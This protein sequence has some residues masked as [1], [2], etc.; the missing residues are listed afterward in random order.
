[1]PNFNKNTITL[2]GRKL[3]QEA[4]IG[5]KAISFQKFSIGD[6]EYPD[7]PEILTALSHEL[8][9]VPVAKT[10]A[11]DTEAGVTIARCSF[12][13]TE[14]KGD[15]YLRE[16]GIFAKLVDSD[17]SPVLFAYAYDD[18]ADFIPSVGAAS[19]IE[20]GIVMHIV[21]GSAEVLYVVDPSAAT[22][23]KDIQELE[24]RVEDAMN[25]LNEEVQNKID[26]FT[27]E[28]ITELT[29]MVD[30]VKNDVAAAREEI[31]TAASG[32]VAKTGDTMT[33]NLNLGTN[34]VIGS[35]QG[36][37]TQWNGWT[38]YNSISEIGNLSWTSSR[39]EI[40][41]AMPAKSIL[42]HSFGA[43]NS[44]MPA[45]TGLLEIRKVDSSGSMIFTDPAGYSWVAGVNNNSC[46]DWR[47]SFGVPTGSIQM[48]AGATA[49]AGYLLC[50][51]QSVSRSTYANLFAAIGTTYGNNDSSTFK[52]PDLRGVFPRGYDAGRGL[53]SGRKLGS[54]QDSGSPNIS[55][56]WGA[57]I[58]WCINDFSSQT[59]PFYRGAAGNRV[60]MGGGGATD[61]VK[62]GL[63]ASKSSSVYKNGLS[64]VRPKNLAVNFIIKY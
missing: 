23:L 61:T 63:D 45:A 10:Y 27:E 26:A 56:I 22:S 24:A 4:I 48:F 25:G 43:K 1:M 47:T 36:S 52:L 28:K 13:N 39:S 54:Y 18:K 15:F 58:T 8:F 62:I 16:I 59:A 17:A 12:Q 51:G 42:Y 11:S 2:E 6:G 31:E 34:K 5:N 20:Q 41:S 14:E 60:S 37:A 33:G 29:E 49:P 19:F 3:L 7:A 55:G 35:L 40:F 53:D 44:T 32:F 64:E 50:Q 9:T 57:A 21:T 30:T 46:S 38:V